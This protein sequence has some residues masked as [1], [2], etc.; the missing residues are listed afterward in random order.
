MKEINENTTIKE[1][2]EWY[3]TEHE[4]TYLLPSEFVPSINRL[5][6]YCYAKEGTNEYSMLSQVMYLLT[7]TKNFLE[8]IKH[9][10]NWKIKS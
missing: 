3:Y 5:E 7:S 9:Y 8:T 4:N 10:S 6:G 2:M 1:F